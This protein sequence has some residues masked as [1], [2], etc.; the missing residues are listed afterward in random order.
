MSPRDVYL[1]QRL[2]P[3]DLEAAED[4]AAHHARLGPLPSLEDEL[5]PE[6]EASGLLGR[7]GAG[8]PVGRKWRSVA[9]R[10]EGG[11]VVIANGAEG[12]PASHK[13]RTLMRVRPH[14]VIDGLLLA[15]RAVGADE[16]ILYVGGEHTAAC[17]ALAR[18]LAERPGSAGDPPISLVA[19]PEGYVSGES[20]AVVHYLQ[21]GDPRPTTV[22]PR[23]FEQ[24]LGGLPTLVQNVESLAHAALISRFGAQSYR[25]RGLGDVRGMALITLSGAVARPGVYEIEYGETLRAVVARAGGSSGPS[26]AVL[27]GG[28]F[29]GWSKVADRWDAPLDPAALAAAGTSFGCGVVAL[30]PQV[31][32]GVRST[33]RILRYMAESSAAQCGPCLYGLGAMSGACQ[34]L[35]DGFVDGDELDLMRHWAGMVAGRGGCHHPDGAIAFLLSALDVFA[36]DLAEHARGRGCLASAAVVAAG[37]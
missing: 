5:I 30:L 18:A 36:A 37:A 15:A 22:P 29:G 13:D 27:L 4:L 20:S 17:D 32:C 10:N 12:E 16:A 31:S 6:L 14:L 9:E 1:R 2:L 19:A 28:Y 26:S 8:F 35:A 25:Q 7:G 34:R 33:A 21:D 11:A 24:G 3:D 23:P